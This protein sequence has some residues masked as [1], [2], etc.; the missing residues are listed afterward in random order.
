MI[1]FNKLF[2][3]L[4][5]KSISQYSLINDYGISPAQITRFKNNHNVSTN[6]INTMC[7]ILNC[8]IED[9]CEYIKDNKKQ[10]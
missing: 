2:K 9:I 10:H 8:K 6:S 5:E 1:V 4:K 7:E 3:K